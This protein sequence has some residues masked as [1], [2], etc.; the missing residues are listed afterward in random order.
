MKV[1][2]DIFLVY[3]VDIDFEN[4]GMTGQEYVSQMSILVGFFGVEKR[5]P[6]PW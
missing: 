1:R 4:T 2:L 5:H 6:C 3:P